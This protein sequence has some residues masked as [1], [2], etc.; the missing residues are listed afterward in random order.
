MQINVPMTAQSYWQP[1]QVAQVK[2]K[3]LD[4]K[5]MYAVQIAQAATLT[6]VPA[7][8]INSVIFLE[9][10]GK[11]NAKSGT[12]A[13]G[14]MQVTPDTASGVIFLTR[15]AGTLTAD[16][17]A[18][19]I[20]L[21]GVRIPSIEKQHYM[22]EAVKGNTAVTTSEL[23]NPSLNILI[24]SMLLA[25]LIAQHT[26]SGVVRLDKVITRYN[27]GYFYKPKGT[28]AELL[29]TVPTETKT[30][31]LKLVGSNSTMDILTA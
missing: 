6:G 24:G 3:L 2:G 4:I 18:L 19:L 22:N 7:D 27:K 25:L 15:K 17:R 26:E 11:A 31:I 8:L 5:A 12:G 21:L 23:F 16:L 13:A 30:Y 10:A 14:L 1:A 9:S 28:V 20:S 29:A